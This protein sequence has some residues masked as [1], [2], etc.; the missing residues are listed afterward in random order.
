MFLQAAVSILDEHRKQERKLR[1]QKIQLLHAYRKRR[2]RK[3]LFYCMC[4]YW[5]QVQWLYFI[6]LF[7][8]GN[9]WSWECDSEITLHKIQRHVKLPASEVPQRYLSEASIRVKSRREHNHWWSNW[10]Q[11]GTFSKGVDICLPCKITGLEH[12]TDNLLIYCSLWCLEKWL[13]DF[14]TE[15]TQGTE[16][17]LFSAFVLCP[18]LRAFRC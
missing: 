12:C 15:D 18:D 1:S 17:S 7:E 13:P 10:S 2:S 3:V 8:L 4:I 5:Q 16:P 11:T 9:I 14:L 6:F